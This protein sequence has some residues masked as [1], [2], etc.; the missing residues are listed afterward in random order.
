MPFEKISVK[1]GSIFNSFADAIVIPRSTTGTISDTIKN[2]VVQV[3]NVEIPEKLPYRALGTVDINQYTNRDRSNNLKPLFHLLFVT[4]VDNDTS[5]FDAIEKIAKEV[6]EFTIANPDVRDVAVP[7]IGTGSG[8]LDHLKVYHI[9][10]TN[11][12]KYASEH[13]VL[14]IYITNERIYNLVG[15]A[16]NPYAPSSPP[17]SVPLTAEQR[18]LME[19]ILERMLK[20]HDFYLAG[21]QSDDGEDRAETFIKNNNWENGHEQKFV[22][23]VKDIK[24]GSI[25]FLKSTFTQDDTHYLRIKGV[26][27]VNMNPEDGQL[28][29]VNW[30]IHGVQYD[31][32]HMGA[33]ASTITKINQPVARQLIKNMSDWES[34]IFALFRADDPTWQPEIQFQPSRIAGLSN[35]S[36]DGEDYLD[37]RNDIDAFAKIMAAEPFKPPL[38]I[39]LFGKWGSGKSFFMKKL[40]EQ[41]SLY[42]HINDEKYCNGIAQI[43]FN[44]WS[45]LDANLWA[46]IVSRIFEQLGI[47]FGEN[48]EDEKITAEIEEKLN[49]QLRLVNDQVQLFGKKRAEVVAEQKVLQDKRDTLDKQLQVKLKSIGELSL[50][51]AFK[52]VDTDF[53]ASE[54]IKDAIAQNEA[55]SSSRKEIEKIIPKE[56]IDDPTQAYESAKSVVSFIRGFFRRDMI[57]WNIAYVIALSLLIYL[58][59]AFLGKFT[60]WL[61]ANH[62]SVPSLQVISSGILIILPAWNRILVFY[63]RWQPMVAALWKVKSDYEREVAVAVEQQQQAEKE[64]EFSVQATVAQLAVLDQQLLEKSMAITDLNFRIKHAIGTEALY[65]FIEKRYKSDDYRKHLGIVSVIRNDFEVLS[66]LFVN[67]NKEQTDKVP[68][69]KLKKPLQRI[70]LYIDD[71]DRCPEDRVVEVLEAVNLLM[72]FPLFIVVVG[73]DPRWIKN[74]LIR[75][76]GMQFSNDTSD[77]I[78]SSDYLE[79]IF[80]VPFHLKAASDQSIKM[81]IRTLSQPADKSGAEAQ[82]VPSRDDDTLVQDQEMTTPEKTEAYS[83][84]VTR[85][86]ERGIL[87]KEERLRLSKHEIGLM[88][89]MSVILGNNPRAIKRFVNIYQIVRAHAGLT[90]ITGQEDREFLVI[91]FLVALYNGAHRRIAPCFV[92]Y[93]HHPQKE[94]KQ[95]IMFLQEHDK[96]TKEEVRLQTELYITLID[97]PSY[98]DLLKVNMATFKAHSAFIQRF[99]FEEFITYS[100]IV[101][102]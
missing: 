13:A 21:S 37:I 40:Q 93:M 36:D 2:D 44:A 60:A 81:M 47:Y 83:S 39:A 75:R 34:M 27:I 102:D 10:T 76:Y 88:E 100:D 35:D 53:K 95:L 5:T 19:I 69:H 90:Y 52:Q 9:L 86:L 43:H 50:K 46:S 51:Q 80:Q 17:S 97:N 73:V 101:Q 14:E 96:L 11:F 22:P 85:E 64:L 41:V 77:R 89:D 78:D 72:A 57:A 71:L 33:Y 84:L 16:E 30:R 18:N 49:E 92:K 61:T 55:F 1:L 7:L 6:A 91:M 99:C 25:I 31:I 65:S 62:L 26:G 8:R 70:I 79:K 24:P 48:S 42:A 68:I 94:E 67:G 98:I 12:I 74:S 63:R 28:L 23:L 59:P 66:K 56:Y 38:A 4:C 82:D 29:S 87:T 45:Y 15:Q 20:E 32:A 3:L 58:G 54:K